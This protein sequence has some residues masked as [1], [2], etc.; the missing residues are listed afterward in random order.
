[1]EVIKMPDTPLNPDALEVGAQSMECQCSK[2]VI[3]C[4]EYY[5]DCPRHVHYPK[6]VSA[7]LAVAQPVV[8]S[9]E[10]LDKLPVGTVVYASNHI[11]P[12][13]RFDIGW[14]GCGNTAAWTSP[15]LARDGL[16]ARVLYRP[17]VNDA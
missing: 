9:V 16:P 15:V 8:S 3:D 14:M 17:E 2:H 7:Y 4:G 5:A 11:G 13:E 1:M 12:A 10:E 6:A